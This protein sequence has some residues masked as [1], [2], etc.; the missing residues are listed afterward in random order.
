MTLDAAPSHTNLKS[1]MAN[2]PPLHDQVDTL[3]ASVEAAEEAARRA[4]GGGAVSTAWRAQIDAE[5]RKARNES[6]FLKTRVR[7][8]RV[9]PATATSRAWG[10][11]K[12][13]RMLAQPTC[14]LTNAPLPPPP[15][16][17]PW[18]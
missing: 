11:R 2:P 8:L 3:L 7:Y 18:L 14:H 15:T 17:S 16:I 1:F 5:V 13:P 10:I 6:S 4:A 9:A 12:H